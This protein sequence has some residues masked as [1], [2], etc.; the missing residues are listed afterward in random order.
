[1]KIPVSLQRCTSY[2]PGMVREALKNTLEPLGG[3]SAF[4]SPG[5]RVLLK[6]NLLM[7][8]APEAAVTTHPEIVKAVALEVMDA[9]AK[10]YL[11][12]SQAVGSFA[13]ILKK[14]G[15]GNVMDDLGIQGVPFRTPKVFSL[16]EGGVYRSLELA[17]E[18]MEYDAM[19]NLPKLKT[20]GQMVLTMAVKN[21]FGTVV[22]AAKTGWHLKAGNDLNMADL[23][24]DIN[25]IVIPVLNVLDA[26]TA[27]EGNGPSGGDQRQ[28]GLLAASPVA[29]ALDQVVASLVGVDPARHPLLHRALEREIEGSETHEVKVLGMNAGEAA[30]GDFVL[31]SSVKKVD[32]ELPGYVSGPL[33]RTLTTYPA[34]DPVT[35]TACGL[36]EKICPVS[37]IRLYENGGGDVDRD[38]CISC[39]CCQEMCPEGAI[40]PVPGRL[41][42]LFKKMG[43][44]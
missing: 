15:I 3:M 1:M 40:E 23:L 17:A 13:S 11:G 32:F 8:K 14:T 24:I 43:I 6:P 19:V 16:P 25:R 29:M 44:A 27:M 2:E 39:F 5:Q 28:V 41:L 38:L 7:G 22:G 36:C 34:L 35:C 30:V 18:A 9:G 4:V 42:K 12:D 31:P 10:V 37:A 21:L 33:K 26:V 20:H